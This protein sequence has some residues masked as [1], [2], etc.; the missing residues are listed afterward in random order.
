MHERLAP[1]AAHPFLASCRRVRVGC[2]L[3]ARFFFSVLLTAGALGHS[4][5]ASWINSLS[6][7]LRA[8]GKI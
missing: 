4:G 7:H 6:F 2:P 8:Y 3:V 5:L 1:C